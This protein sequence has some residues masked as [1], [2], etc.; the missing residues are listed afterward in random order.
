MRPLRIIAIAYFL[1]CKFNWYIFHPAVKG[2]EKHLRS[3]L[4]PKS[5]KMSEAMVSFKCNEDED[6]EIKDDVLKGTKTCKLSSTFPLL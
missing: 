4:I 1:L 6:K 3:L 2:N 5:Q